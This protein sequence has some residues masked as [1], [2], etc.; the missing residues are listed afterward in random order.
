MRNR[1]DEPASQI[2]GESH[3]MYIVTLVTLVTLV[4]CEALQGALV[5]QCTC[6][7]ESQSLPEMASMVFIL[8]ARQR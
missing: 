2:P 8:Q 3:F 6:I 4:T 1:T 5:K 7:R